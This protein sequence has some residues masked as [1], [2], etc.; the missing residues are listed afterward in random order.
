MS[1]KHF[2]Y[3]LLWSYKPIFISIGWSNIPNRKHFSFLRP[4]DAYTRLWT[5]SSLVQV[6]ACRLLGVKPLT[7]PTRMYCRILVKKHQWTCYRNSSIFIEENDWL[8]LHCHLASLEAI[9][10]NKGKYCSDVIMGTMASQITGVSKVYSTFCSGA[11]QRKHQNSASRAFVRGIH[12]SPKNSPQ[13]KPITRKM[14][15]FD[16]VIMYITSIYLE[17]I[18]WPQ[19][20]IKANMCTHLVG[21]VVYVGVFRQH[22]LV[23]IATKATLYDE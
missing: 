17:L 2:T 19:E 16:D 12:R 14:F 4:S 15:S 18:V 8:L 21:Y 22:L 9:L 6:M 1:H 7:K 20:K 3:Q 23:T 10:G 5:A 13:K 11:N